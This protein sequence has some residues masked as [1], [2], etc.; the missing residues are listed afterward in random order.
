MKKTI[1]KFIKQD[2]GEITIESMLVIIPTIFVMLFLLSLGFLLYQQWNLQVA[3][4]DAANKIAG[5]FSMLNASTSTGEIATEDYRKVDLYR[6]IDIGA[7]GSKTKYQN[8]NKEKAK[9]YVLGRM[10]G[11]SF[12]NTVGEPSV[13]CT[14]ESNG[15]ARKRIQLSVTA[16]YKIPFGE[17]LELMGM[18][19]ERTCNAT[20]AAECLDILDYVN[21]VT[22]ADVAPSYFEFSTLEAI[23]S[24]KKVLVSIMNFGS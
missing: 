22:V 4:D 14:V 21:A 6:N 23:D 20:S 7:I 10:N 24:W 17:G 5:S 16:T 18:D 15:F 11:T 9:T 12:A 13:S 8:R 19:S 3:T 1:N 2:K